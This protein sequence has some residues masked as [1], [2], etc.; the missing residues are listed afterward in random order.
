MMKVLTAILL[1][2]VSTFSI[3]A[4]AA[5]QM[6]CDVSTQ[7]NGSF[8]PPSADNCFGFDYSFRNQT[9]VTF[10]IK[11]NGQQILN[12]IWIDGCS[13]SNGAMTCSTNLRAYR[14][15]TAR[16]ILILPG[17]TFQEVSATASYESGY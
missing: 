14:F 9:N 10:E 7:G 6:T 4:M 8:S 12:V 13:A 2:L 16:A 17:N 5:S 11:P 15:L 1:I 3:K